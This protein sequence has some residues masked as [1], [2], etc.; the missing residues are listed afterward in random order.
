MA[1]TIDP[2][3]VGCWNESSS[4]IFGELRSL[5]PKTKIISLAAE[6]NEF[7]IH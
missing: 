2:S 6:K 3:K 1:K 7:D 4:W 5:R